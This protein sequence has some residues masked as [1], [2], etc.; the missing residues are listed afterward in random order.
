[1]VYKQNTASE[2]NSLMF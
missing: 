2:S 1:M